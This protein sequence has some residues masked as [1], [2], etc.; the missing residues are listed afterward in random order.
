MG[1]GMNKAKTGMINIGSGMIIAETG[2]ISS[3]FQKTPPR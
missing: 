3:K 1:Y 2:M